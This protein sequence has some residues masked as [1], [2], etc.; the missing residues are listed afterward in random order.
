MFNR[1]TNDTKKQHIL[2]KSFKLIKEEL[3]KLTLQENYNLICNFLVF[4]LGITLCYYH[5]QWFAVGGIV[6]LLLLR[7]K[8]SAFLMLLGFV[9]MKG[10]FARHAQ[11]LIDKEY[12]YVQVVAHVDAVSHRGGNS[13]KYTLSNLSV[14]KRNLQIEGKIMAYCRNCKLLQIQ[15]GST[16]KATM[17]IVA[18]PEKV[19][20]TGYDVANKYRFKGFSGFAFINKILSL[21]SKTSDTSI[22]IFITLPEKIRSFFL[23]TLEDKNISNQTRAVI[24]AIFFGEK[25]RISK[26]THNNFRRVGI[27]HIVAIS[28]MHISIVMLIFHQIFFRIFAT[29]KYLRLKCNLRKVSLVPSLVCTFCYLLIAGMPISGLRSFVMISFATIIYTLNAKPKLFSSVLFA[30]FLL[31]TLFP[32]EL[33]FASFQLSFL[34]VL[35]FSLV[36]DNSYKIKNIFVRYFYTIAKSSIVITLITA[37]VVIYHFGGISLISPFMNMFAIPF[38]TLIIMPSGICYF[39]LTIIPIHTNLVTSF[40]STIMVESLTKMLDVSSFFASF[41]TAFIS[42]KDMPF[43]AVVL[44]LGGILAVL[45][46][47]SLLKVIGFLCVIVGL[48]MFIFS[49][50]PDIIAN[51]KSFAFRKN[52]K[53]YI[54]GKEDGFP[55]SIWRSK[56]GLDR[57]FINGE[58]FCN[59]DG[60]CRTDKITYIKENAKLK[61]LNG[62]N[63]TDI[64]V[65]RI[66]VYNLKKLDCKYKVI[67]TKDALQE[68][69]YITLKYNEI[70]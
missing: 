1:E 9:A 17:T 39:L 27:S 7:H 20:P 43:F 40:F 45:V 3:H 47:K 6:A 57:D 52:G 48:V 50:T 28:G 44:I 55:Q 23:R 21:N 60:I 66:E 5:L 63:C 53:Y 68:K 59:E 32:H 65:S 36:I 24:E 18:L 46:V 41:N 15:S 2:S 62:D 30:G 29:S 14:Q 31:L 25:S 51:S 22:S 38:L 61:H 16:V 11:K 13:I 12:K 26:E 37:P 35:S 58:K 54:L 19:Y 67:I 49:Q 10:D 33:F 42:L 64:L 4:A 34:A 8:A 70:G 69:P 56:L